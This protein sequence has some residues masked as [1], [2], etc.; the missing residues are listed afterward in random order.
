MPLISFTVNPEH[1]KITEIVQGL[2]MCGLSSLTPEN[3]LK[4]NISIIIN[5]T[6]EVP[7]LQSLGNIPRIKLWLEDTP[8]SSIY[9]LLDSQT[10]QIESVIASGGNVLVHCVTGVSLSA[11]ICLAFLTKFRCKSLKQAYELMVCKRPLVR[12][13][14]GFWRQLIAFEQDIK[15]NVGTVHLVTDKANPYQLIP[16]VYLNGQNEISKPQFSKA[17]DN[18][19]NCCGYEK[20]NRRN[21]NDKLKFQPVLEPVLEVAA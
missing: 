11:T 20:Q 16:D 17:I 14:I 12:P 7:N 10:D 19:E 21:S 6:K 8:R 9:E 2:Y 4:Y 18:E 1:A 5:A 13:N 3:V 15:K